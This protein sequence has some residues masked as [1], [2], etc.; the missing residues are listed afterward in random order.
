MKEADLRRIMQIKTY[1][2]DI[3]DT[4]TRF[5]M[6]YIAFENDRDFVNSVSMSIMQIG[7]LSVS[8]SD[9]FKEESGATIQWN[10]LK[11]IRNLFAHA[12]VSMNKAIIWQSAVGDIP[13]LLKFC[14]KIIEQEIKT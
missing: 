3:A 11:G 5:G 1:C 2:E 10:A 14:V 4:I 9:S 7:E 8:L 13:E 6:N 12:Y